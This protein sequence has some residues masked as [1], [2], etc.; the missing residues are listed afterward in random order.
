MRC[1]RTGAPPESGRV[2]RQ[3]DRPGPHDHL[4]QGLNHRQFDHEWYRAMALAAGDR[5]SGNSGLV[6]PPGFHRSF[7]RHGVT[8][9]RFPG[10]R[11]RHVVGGGVRCDP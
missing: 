6:G 2:C 4:V 1:D 3:V 9:G 7:D 11:N 8:G 5:K 10:V